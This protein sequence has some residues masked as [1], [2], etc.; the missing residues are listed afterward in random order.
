MLQDH[1]FIQ[2]GIPSCVGRKPE[3]RKFENEMEKKNHTF[4]ETFY[5]HSNKRKV[6]ALIVAFLRK[7]SLGSDGKTKIDLDR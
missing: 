4:K 5:H 2:Y 3:K 7:Q 1:G 6:L